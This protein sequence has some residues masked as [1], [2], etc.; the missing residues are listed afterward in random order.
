MEVAEMA[1]Y[2]P[3]Q[4]YDLKWIWNLSFGV[5][6]G[7][8]NRPD[9]VQLIQHA[10]NRIMNSIPFFDRQGRP[11]KSYLKRDGL[12]GPRTETAIW[13]FQEHLKGKKIYIN[14]DGAADPSDRTGYTRN[15]MIYT[16]VQ[17]NRV[18]LQCFGVMM[19]EADFPN[20][21]KQTAE[22]SLRSGPGRAA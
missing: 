21:L 22:A 2:F 13:A 12:F 5:G 4:N 7:R 8:A 11:I 17:F 14:V 18:H 6:Q 19:D 16:I 15:D 20:P 10:F 3:M 1:L 9:D